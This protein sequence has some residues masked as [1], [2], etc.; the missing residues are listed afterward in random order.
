MPL[1]PLPTVP[2][3]LSGEV[4]GIDGAKVWPVLTDGVLTLWVCRGGE[5]QRAELDAGAVA[6]LRD[7][8]GDAA[9]RMNGQI[10]SC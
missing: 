3:A 10:L 6:D 4:V 9:A 7:L 8:L 5:M 1:A 2:H